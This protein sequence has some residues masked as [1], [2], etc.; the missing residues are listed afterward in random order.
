MSEEN[1]AIIRRFI[2]DVNKRD[3]AVAAKLIATNFIS[4]IP[5]FAGIQGL[6]GWKQIDTTLRTAFPDGQWTIEDMVAEGDKVVARLTA[7]GTHQGEYRG[8]PPTGKQVTVQGTVTYRISGGQ[9]AEYWGNADDLGLMQQL[10][11][12]PPIGQAGR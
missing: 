3:Q 7:R 8:I 9:I 12:V 10:G 11:V 2:E 6:E 1:K 5:G 4:H